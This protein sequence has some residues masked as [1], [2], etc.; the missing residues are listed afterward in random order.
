MIVVHCPV[1]FSGQQEE[2]ASVIIPVSQKRKPRLKLT[3]STCGMVVTQTQV[4][5]APLLVTV[6]STLHYTPF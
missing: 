4:V 6:T 5:L 1:S 3:Q 2:G